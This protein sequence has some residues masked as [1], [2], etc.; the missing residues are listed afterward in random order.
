MSHHLAPTTAICPWTWAQYGWFLLQF[1]L[2]STYLFH[3]EL[4]IC[5]SIK[6]CNMIFGVQAFYFCYA[7]VI[8]TGKVKYLCIQGGT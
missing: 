1:T 2:R 5:A 3:E 7:K 6:G 4:C 8:N